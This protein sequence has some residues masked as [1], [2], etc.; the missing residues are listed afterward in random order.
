MRKNV[1]ASLSTICLL[2]FCV[3]A[4]AQVQIPG[5]PAER[6]EKATGYGMAYLQQLMLGTCQKMFPEV[7]QFKAATEGLIKVTAEFENTFSKQ[8][9]SAIQNFTESAYKEKVEPTLTMNT[10]A[11]SECSETAQYVAREITMGV[12]SGAK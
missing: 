11:F 7:P 1:T 6:Q 10:D 9:I 2:M 3:V 8:E 5:V 4:T 12:F